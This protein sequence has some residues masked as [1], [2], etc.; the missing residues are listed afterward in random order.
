MKNFDA[1]LPLIYPVV[2][3]ERR[4][5]EASY[6]RFSAHTRSDMEKCSQ[7]VKMVEEIISKL[8]SAAGV[9]FS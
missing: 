2:D 6:V 1:L 7:Q 5:Q 4:V 8:L 3:V 9:P